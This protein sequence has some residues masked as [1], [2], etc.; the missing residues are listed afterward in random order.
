[1]NRAEQETEK[2]FKEV[3]RLFLEFIKAHRY[4]VEFA[5]EAGILCK[6]GEALKHKYIISRNGEQMQFI[7]DGIDLHYTPPLRQPQCKMLIMND[8]EYCNALIPL[9]KD[10]IK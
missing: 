4:Y 5:Q 8:G 1:M 9:R 10:T 3:E 7:I 2:K 6:E